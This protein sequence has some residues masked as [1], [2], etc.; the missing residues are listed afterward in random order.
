MRGGEERT[1]TVAKAAESCLQTGQKANAGE[2]SA[3]P[4][5]FT[6]Q[7]SIAFSK[8]RR[9]PSLYPPVV[10]VPMVVVAAVAEPDC[11][12]PLTVN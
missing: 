2:A 11:L 8:L 12:K 6:T 3:A 9:N 7:N 4:A 5:L 1:G 10:P